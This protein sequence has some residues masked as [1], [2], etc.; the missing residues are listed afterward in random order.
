MYS[1]VYKNIWNEFSGVFVVV[2]CSKITH[3]NSILTHL[4]KERKKEKI[5]LTIC[6]Y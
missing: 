4:L 1:V 2:F 3:R 5:Q 6:F